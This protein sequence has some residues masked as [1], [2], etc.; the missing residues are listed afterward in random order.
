MVIFGTGIP[1][2]LF[3]GELSSKKEVGGL[4]TRG[5]NEEDNPFSVDK[6]SPPLMQYKWKAE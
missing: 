4:S 5:G 6:M 3:F 1:T 2:E